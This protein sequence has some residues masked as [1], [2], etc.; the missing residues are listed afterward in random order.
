MS[1]E[2]PDEFLPWRGQLTA[3]DALPE[4]GVDD[5]EQSWQRLAERTPEANPRRPRIAWWIA[6]ACLILA[7]FF[8]ASHPNRV[9]H[10][11]AIQRQP[12]PENPHLTLSS[13]NNTTP[14][15]QPASK[16]NH[17][18]PATTTIPAVPDTSPT[19]TTT[20]ASL[21]PN[22]APNL[23]PIFAA[24]PGATSSAP[25]A[26]TGPPHPL[27]IVYLNEI[28]KDPGLSPDPEF[29]QPAFLRLSIATG[30]TINQNNTSIIKIDISSPNH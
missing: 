20:L 18:S 8:P 30:W 1:N 13:P 26:T 12:V 25:L 29:R 11:P 6:A 27:R 7:F 5:K 4:M 15:L 21:I 23:A 28:G 22:P 3:P 10:R 19:T 16:H 9:A 17:P 24:A 14:G 2:R